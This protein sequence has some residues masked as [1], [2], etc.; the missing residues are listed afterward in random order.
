MAA[1]ANI[2]KNDRDVLI[3]TAMNA[4]KRADVRAQ[5]V[6]AGLDPE[7]QDGAQL[8]RAIDAD[9]KVWAKMLAEAGV[10]PE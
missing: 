4:L 5:L 6:V 2:A 8:A 7:P 3:A 1:P 9:I 10:Q